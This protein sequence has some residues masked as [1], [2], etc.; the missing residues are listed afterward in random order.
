MNI[1]EK[2]SFYFSLAFKDMTLQEQEDQSEL[3]QKHGLKLSFGD[4]TLDSC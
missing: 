4:Q 1:F 3:R 2:I